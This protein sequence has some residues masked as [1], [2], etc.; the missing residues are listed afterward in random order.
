M[1]LYGLTL[2]FWL[3]FLLNFLMIWFLHRQICQKKSWRV[4][5]WSWTSR[6][7]LNLVL[8][9]LGLRGMLP[10][11]WFL[12]LL[13]LEISIGTSEGSFLRFEDILPSKNG[14]SVVNGKGNSESLRCNFQNIVNLMLICIEKWFWEKG[15]QALIKCGWGGCCGLAL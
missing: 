11:M 2:R 4:G 13:A 12:E 10:T 1:D 6:Q 5:V 7:H 14:V 8:V 15:I 9:A 3:N